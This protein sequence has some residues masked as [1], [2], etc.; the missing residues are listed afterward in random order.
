MKNKIINQ[1]ESSMAACLNNEQLEKLKSVL[2]SS[3]IDVNV[4]E[5]ANI[6]SS[7][8]NMKY[9]QLFIASKQIEGC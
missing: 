5:I 6:D 1:I 8:D 7:E 3:L 4:V 2:D 9:L